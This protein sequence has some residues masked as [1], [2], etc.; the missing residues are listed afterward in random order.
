MPVSNKKTFYT[1]KD[2]EKTCLTWLK[3]RQKKVNNPIYCSAG[4][5]FC[6]GL[7]IIIQSAILARLI[8]LIIIDKQYWQDLII[9]FCL[10]IAVFLLRACCHYGFQH[11]GH[12]AAAISKQDIRSELIDHFIMLGPAY[13]KQMHSGQLTAYT[14]EHIEALD[15]YFS[16]YLPQK[17]IVTV[18]PFLT[19]LLVFPVN[20]VVACIFL[21]CGP[22]IPLFM[23]LVGMGAESAHKQ[24]FNRLNRMSG[25]FLDRL[26]GLTTLNLFG[27]A[28]EEISHIADI[29]A[30]FAEYTLRI[31]RIAFLSSAVLEFFSALAVAL[32]AVYVGL[33]LLGLVRFGPAQGIR[34]EE[35]IFV[36]LLAPEFFAPLKQLAAYYHDKSAAV[37][38]TDHLLTVLEKTVKLSDEDAVSKNRNYSLEIINLDKSFENN[39]IF[40]QFNIQIK[41]GENIALVS[42]SGVGK[43]TLF[44]LILQN[45]TPDQGQIFIHGTALS[46]EQIQTQI[47]WSS[48]RP[49]FFRSSLKNNITLFKPDISQQDLEQAAELTGVTEFSD[50]L[51]QGL[52][53]QVSEFAF[54]L[55]GGQRQRLALAR[56]FIKNASIILLDEPTA[57]L[58]QEN[59]EK[60]TSMILKLFSKH[61]LVV[62]SHDQELVAKM[63]RTVELT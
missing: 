10:L 41:P 19:I 5:G 61:T 35:A 58:D 8:H 48:Q 54:E 12:K 43:S 56:I 45:D 40:D 6:N 30:D 21:I 1:Y 13:L 11:F 57:N 37:A 15:L 27:R 17:L 25:Y 46:Q 34:L 31:L 23:A 60:I 52:E 38:A 63:D 4:M 53:H 51:E 29:S 7:F 22:L 2:R 36:L 20:W 33:G 39:T 44:D 14:L 26:Q 3:K 59:R 24:L 49:Y 55:S 42:E 50:L 18:L 9:E 32:V 16:R 28:E 62:A 47:A